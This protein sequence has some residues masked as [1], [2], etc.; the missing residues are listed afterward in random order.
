MHPVLGYSVASSNIGA[1]ADSGQYGSI[2]RVCP[3]RSQNKSLMTASSRRHRINAI[4][5][6]QEI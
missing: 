1:P 6:A 2:R 4:N 5:N 3:R